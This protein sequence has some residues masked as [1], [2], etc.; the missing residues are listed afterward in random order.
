[1]AAEELGIPYERVQAIIADTNALG[2]NETTG[3]S[4]VAHS[5]GMATIEAAQSAIATM[6][7]RVAEMWGI[8]PDAVIW[9][10]G[11]AKPS[12]SNAGEFEP[13]SL[14]EITALANNTGGPIAG[15][16]EIN[17]EG[18]GTSF[19]THLVD[20]EVDPDTGY[21]TVLRYLVVQDAG[22]AV[23]P[24]YV[25]GQ[26]QG[27]AVQGIGWALNEEYIYGED[28]KL[29]NAGFLDYRM[30]VASDLPMI[31]TVIVESPTPAIPTACVGVGETPIVRRSQRWPT[32]WPVPPAAGSPSCRCRRR[33]S[34]PRSPATE[35]RDMTV[36]V[37]LGS[38]LSAAAGGRTEFEV[39]AKNVM[40]LL[41]ALGKD[42]P[43][44]EPVLERGVAVAIDGQL[45][46]DALL[47]PIRRGG[48]LSDAEGRRRIV[49]KEGSGAERPAR[50]RTMSTTGKKARAVGIN[51]VALEVDDIDEALE[52][53]GRFVE[54]ELE[55]KTDDI[56]FIYLGDQFINFSKGRRQ[57]PDDG[58]HIGLVVDDK[59]AV[60]ATLEDMG[61]EIMPGRFLDFLDPWGNRVEIVS[62]QNI[63]FTKAPNVLRGMGLDDLG[64]NETALA[65]LQDNG[66]G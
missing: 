28:G 20:V 53:Y 40:Q 47:Q 14:A 29:Q 1:M 2:Y 50:V 4:R 52:F 37:R 62:Y 54:F 45:Y 26:Y 27:G 63:R 49:D 48:G 64:K 43:E 32:R 15:H 41:R 7:Q 66:M 23:H 30:P 18:A 5:A 21:V 17:A 16:A 61:V 11:H 9:E 8:D 35:A 6:R 22:K 13:M 19:G 46:R 33:R 65:E 56:A 38:T 31:D 44:L 3:G 36:C 57:G 51:H 12:G 39:E 59:E 25:E 24:S 10:D 34:W 42:Y 58:R 60:R 55:S